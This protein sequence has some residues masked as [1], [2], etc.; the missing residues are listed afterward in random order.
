MSDLFAAIEPK[1]EVA[2]IPQEMARQIILKNARD[3]EILGAVLLVK[4]N[5]AITYCAASAILRE[6]VADGFVSESDRDG[7]R[8]LLRLT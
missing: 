6:L 5:M 1:P 4:S 7:R 2:V 3:G 8:R